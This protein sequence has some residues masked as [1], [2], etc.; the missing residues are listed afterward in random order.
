MTTKIV[1]LVLQNR[2]FSLAGAL[3]GAIF[4][5]A[6]VRLVLQKTRKKTT[7][8]REAVRVRFFGTIK[9]TPL[10]S[11]TLLFSDL[12]PEASISPGPA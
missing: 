3:N 4:L 5:Y 1:R 9:R 8:C 6:S 11:S 2:A 12:R 10:F 7:G